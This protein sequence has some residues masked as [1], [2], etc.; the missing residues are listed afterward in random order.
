MEN[1]EIPQCRTSSESQEKQNN[2]KKMKNKYYPIVITVPKS[3]EKNRKKQI[4]IYSIY[5][6]PFTFLVW[7]NAK[8]QG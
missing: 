8:W 5:T 4:D 3:N 1:K 6:F 7:C 2:R